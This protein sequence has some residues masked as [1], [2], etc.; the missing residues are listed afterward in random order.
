M[1]D[2]PACPMCGA[3]HPGVFRRDAG[4]VRAIR[5][6]ASRR[7]PVHTDGQMKVHG[8]DR[9]LGGRDAGRRIAQPEI[10]DASVTA[11]DRR[12]D[13]AHLRGAVSP[14]RSQRPRA[15]T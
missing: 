7:R 5:G 3:D 14:A 13:G 12:N 8:D 11:T 4:P 1:P 9:R 2:T 15:R 10:R 6:P